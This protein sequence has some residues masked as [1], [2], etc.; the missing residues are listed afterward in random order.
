MK[1][2]SC[3]ILHPFGFMTDDECETCIGKDEIYA[4]G[5]YHKLSLDKFHFRRIYY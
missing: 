2:M 4:V 5:Q 1:I 3:Q